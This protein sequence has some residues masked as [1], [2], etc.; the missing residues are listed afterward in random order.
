MTGD[1][2]RPVCCEIWPDS[3]VDTKTLIE[4]NRKNVQPLYYPSCMASWPI[5]T[6]SAVIR[7]REMRK[8]GMLPAVDFS[9]AMD[10]KRV[11]VI[12]EFGYARVHHFFTFHGQV[13]Q[14]GDAQHATD[15]VDLF[16]QILDGFRF[17]T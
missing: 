10:A 13:Q 1:R 2:A 6:R 4:N 12:K 7:G 16:G 17:N 14:P 9:I 5:A 8:K 3:I 11:I 15:R